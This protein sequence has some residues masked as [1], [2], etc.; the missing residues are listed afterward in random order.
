MGAG[1]TKSEVKTAN[2]SGP[3]KASQVESSAASRNSI[4]QGSD[5]ELFDLLMKVY[6]KTKWSVD[7]NR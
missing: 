5:P 3:G 2:T 7:P 6:Q 4:S 1:N